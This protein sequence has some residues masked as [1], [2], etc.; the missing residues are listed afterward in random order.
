MEK[1]SADLGMSLRPQDRKAERAAAAAHRAGLAKQLAEETSP[2][3][4]FQLAL[5]LLYHQHCSGAVHIPTRL[6]AL[7]VEKVRAA[8][9]REVGQDLQQLSDLCVAVQRRRAE[10]AKENPSGEVPEAA[11]RSYA[12]Y[13]SLSARLPDIQRLGAVAAAAAAGTAPAADATPLA[14]LAPAASAAESG[15]APEEAEALARDREERRKRREE[16]MR[17]TGRAVS[18]A[19]ERTAEEEAAVAKER[20]ERRKRREARAGMAVQ[21]P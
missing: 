8:A 14:P 15:L 20:E 6:I 13:A 11:L 10:L 5:L 21:E 17:E 12:P 1:L 9:P 18:G 2:T 7:T 4:A 19:A 16:K 3:A